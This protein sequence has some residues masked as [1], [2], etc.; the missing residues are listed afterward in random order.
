MAAQPTTTG[1]AKSTYCCSQLLTATSTVAE[2]I[3][4]ALGLNVASGEVGAAV[5]Q[6]CSAA[7]TLRGQE[8]W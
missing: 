7:A 6:L 2:E 8:Y 4:S 5:G 1:T 3:L